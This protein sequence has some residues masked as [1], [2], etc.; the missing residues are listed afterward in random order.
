MHGE[1]AIVYVTIAVVVVQVV[2]SLFETV[3]RYWAQDTTAAQDT[4]V[5]TTRDRFTQQEI[6]RSCSKTWPMRITEL[7]R[8]PMRITEIL[9]VQ[10]KIA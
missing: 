3:K 1:R 4:Q 7:L 9:R 6:E 8:V 2:L 10:N 5:K